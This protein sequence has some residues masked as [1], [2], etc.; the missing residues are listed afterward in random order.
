MQ[1]ALMTKLEIGDTLHHYRLD[2]IVAH[3][4]MSTLFKATD[5]EDGK[6]VAIKVPHAE[7][8][9]DPILSERFKREQQIGQELDHPGIVKTYAD[10]HRCRVYM[11]IEWV[12]GRL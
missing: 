8:E 7:M 1:T 2:A 9:S 10:E 12:E 6:Q 11:V 4:S 3:S 5:L